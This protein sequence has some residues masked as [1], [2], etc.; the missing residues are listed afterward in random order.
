MM[1]S[2]SPLPRWSVFT[3][4]LSVRAWEHLHLC[5]VP[6]RR[7]WYALSWFA[8]H[9]HTRRRNKLFHLFIFTAEWFCTGVEHIHAQWSP[10]YHYTCCYFNFRAT[11]NNHLASFP[12]STFATMS[13]IKRWNATATH[14][15]VSAQWSQFSSSMPRHSC[16]HNHQ[17]NWTLG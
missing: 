17:I 4:V 1:T 7:C 15:L 2:S 3:L 11:N 14:F 5:T 10:L 9:Q 16:V 13:W 12:T 6:Y 8:N